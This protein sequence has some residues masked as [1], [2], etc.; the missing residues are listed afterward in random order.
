[1]TRGAD[2]R[3]S[4]DSALV[5]AAE[6][7][8][9]FLGRLHAGVDRS[10][11]QRRLRVAE[12]RVKRIRQQRRFLV[13]QAHDLT[14]PFS[15][16]RRKAK[17]QPPDA[18]GKAAVMAVPVLMGALVFRAWAERG[19]R[20]DLWRMAATVPKAY[21]KASIFTCLLHW[22]LDN[23][24]IGASGMEAVGHHLDPNNLN[25]LSFTEHAH[26]LARHLFAPVSIASAAELALR[27]LA[28]SETDA[29]RTFDRAATIG[30]T[31]FG[32]VE[33]HRLA[34]VPDGARPAWATRMQKA[35]LL[36]S[37]KQHGEHHR[38]PW[39]GNLGDLNGHAHSF[40]ESAGVYTA[41]GRLL[42][43]LSGRLPN[44]WVYAPNLIPID[45]WSRVL[46]DPE[47]VRTLEQTALSHHQVLEGTRVWLSRVQSETA[48]REMSRSLQAAVE[49]AIEQR[50]T[51]RAALG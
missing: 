26:G 19:H 34:H 41:L 23:V 9:S 47:L 50:R 29:V 13:Q 39:T 15:E 16:R 43:R 36:V 20:S 21:V 5:R 24:D 30:L 38:Y 14:L 37:R 4:P 46:G 31:Y 2:S 18:L 6:T 32:A 3:S 35:G 45:L 11:A 33:G 27:R 17:P 51:A 48:R 25:N 1:M 44:S 22:F 42:F 12:R 7:F 40:L 8:G 10:R 28:R 49:P